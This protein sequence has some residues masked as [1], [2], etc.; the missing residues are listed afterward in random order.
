MVDAISPICHIPGASYLSLPFCRSAELGRSSVKFEDLVNVQDNVA[1]LQTLTLYGK[2][3]PAHIRKTELA[4]R[5]L[6]P[7]VRYS[8]LPSHDEL[9]DELS[10]FIRDLEEV[11]DALVTFN[12][13]VGRLVDEALL[14]SR[15][16][17]Q[18]LNK[19]KKRQIWT[20]LNTFFSSDEDAVRREYLRHCEFLQNHLA[21]RIEQADNLRNSLRRMESRF[22]TMG[23]II[24]RDDAGIKI[25]REELL[26]QLF[27][28][29]GGNRESRERLE[30]QLQLLKQVNSYRIYALAHVM[31][32]MAKMQSMAASLKD[33]KE[34]VLTPTAAENRRSP[35][36]EIQLYAVQKGAERLQRL[37][38][39]GTENGNNQRQIEM[40]PGEQVRA[41]SLT[42]SK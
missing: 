1:E 17:L 27:T 9:L 29:L 18:T 7:V 14:S 11:A 42:L 23:K 24:A 26:S 16:V 41:V 10:K 15:W 4:V 13:K 39:E 20:W 32:I 37:V 34:R 25:D 40:A 3:L 12:V 22:D 35:P 36:L 6:R 28:R 8:D 30:E 5:I 19:L 31:G 33:L 2:E 21:K 38:I